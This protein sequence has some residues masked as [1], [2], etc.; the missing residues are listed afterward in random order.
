[1]G[2]SGVIINLTAEPKQR[3]LLLGLWI[4]TL[5][6]ATIIGPLIGG[7]FTSEVTWQ[8]CFWINLPIGG[9]AILLQ[10]LFLRV[11]Q[12]HTKATWKE[13][14]FHLDL[15]SFTVLLV[16]LICLTLAL[17][18]GGLTKPWSDNSVIAVLVMLVVLTITFCLIEWFQGLYAM[19]PMKLLASRIIWSNLV[20]SLM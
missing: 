17:Q 4:G 10:F 15:P 16:S 11:K 14:L 6:F 20:W 1:L 18:W 9:V 13:I 7:V 5:M 3:P 2:G 19:I 12:K 8:W